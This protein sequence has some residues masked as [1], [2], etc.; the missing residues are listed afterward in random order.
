MVKFGASSRKVIPPDATWITF[1]RSDA[2]PDRWPTNTTPNADNT[3]F[4]NYMKLLHIDD[5]KA[6]NWR[7]VIANDVARLLDYPRM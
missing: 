6:N 1:E 3:G 5:E 4:M 2:S 7:I